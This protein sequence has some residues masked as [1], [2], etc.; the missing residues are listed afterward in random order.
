MITIFYVYLL[1]KTVHQNIEPPLSSV[2]YN[3]KKLAYS[4]HIFL[5]FGTFSQNIEW[6]YKLW[7]NLSS[8]CYFI[9]Y[10]LVKK[11]IEFRSLFRFTLN[12]FLGPRKHHTGVGHMLC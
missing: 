4:A 3:K 8:I 2:I 12:R 5:L 6:L 1:T 9:P 11:H 7:E 10:K